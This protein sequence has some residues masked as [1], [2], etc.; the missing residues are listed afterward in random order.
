MKLDLPPAAPRK[1]QNDRPRRIEIEVGAEP[2]SRPRRLDEVYQGMAHV[3]GSNPFL[4]IER[5]LER[6]NHQ[7][8]VDELA[9]L[10]NATAP[11]G[12]HLGADVV[13]NGDSPLLQTL[14][15]PQVKSREVD[16]DRGVRFALLRFVGEAL[17]RSPERRDLPDHFQEAD[18]GDFLELD[19][20]VGAIRFRAR[21]AEAE[22]LDRGNA[23]SKLAQELAGIQVSRRFTRAEENPDG[24]RHRSLT[25]RRRL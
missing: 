21:A 18:H 8:L 6:K 10:S 4:A 14:R 5:L 16:E 9:D 3:V 2:F 19:D 13:E 17:H 12:P 7:H 1:E 20:E 22:R 11:P 23:R 15:E 24:V 25:G